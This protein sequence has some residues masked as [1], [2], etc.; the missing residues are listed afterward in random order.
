MVHKKKNFA[1]VVHL[2]MSSLK[3]R[4]RDRVAKLPTS[5]SRTFRVKAGDNLAEGLF[6]VVKRNLRRLTLMSS[7]KNATV[8]F[9]STAW[10]HKHPG[11]ES[12]AEGIKFYQ[13]SVTDMCHPQE[14]FQNLD[15]LTKTESMQ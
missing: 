12:V 9:L 10:Q 14:A 15:R 6:Q 11:L 13:D 8:N 1:N 7:T 4:L 3:K 5:T 2:P